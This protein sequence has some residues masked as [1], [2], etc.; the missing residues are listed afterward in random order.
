MVVKVI[1]SVERMASR[2]RRSAS[3]LGSLGK[4]GALGIPI[5]ALCLISLSMFLFWHH[6]SLHPDSNAAK[7][8]LGRGAWTLIHTTAA[9]YPQV[10]TETQQEHAK[11]FF[12]SI[13]ALYPCLDCRIH[14]Y[15]FINSKPP[16][17]VVCGE[18][19]T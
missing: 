5:F 14:F 16:E 2:R 7:E 4:L 18:I 12:N 17:Y 1:S 10:P 3:N 11:N 9:K 8:A 13:G 19:Y 15:Q 6:S